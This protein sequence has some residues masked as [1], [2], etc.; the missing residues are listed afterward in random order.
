M[1]FRATALTSTTT[2]L[3]PGVGVGRL[4]TVREDPFDSS[5]A[6][7]CWVVEAMIGLELIAVAGY[8]RSIEVP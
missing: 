2:S 8:M 5:V 3:G 7:A 1:G 6:A 4:T